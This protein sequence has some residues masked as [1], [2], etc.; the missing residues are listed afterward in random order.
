MFLTEEAIWAEEFI[1]SLQIQTE[2]DAAGCVN[3]GWN[4]LCSVLCC[5]P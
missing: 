1:N 4:S 2:M 5:T 3:I